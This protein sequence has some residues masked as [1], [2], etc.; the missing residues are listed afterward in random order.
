MASS[1][2]RLAW[3]DLRASGL[4]VMERLL[5]E[6]ALLRHDPLQ[7]SWAILGTHDPLRHRFIKPQLPRYVT[8]SKDPNPGCIIVMGIGGKPELLLN[9][10][11]V[12][13][14]GVVV[15]KRFSGGGTVVLDNHSIWTTFIGRTKD[16]PSIEPY[17]RSIMQWSADEVFTPAFDKM[18]LVDTSDERRGQKT[19]VMDNKSCSATENI[20]TV[21]SLP[22]SKLKNAPSL[23][24]SPVFELKEN[25]YVLGE[26]KIGGN[27]QSII[28][29]GWL[30]HTSF[31]W[32]FDAEHMEYLTLP[33]KR[34]DY[35][36]DR[37]HEEFLV[38]LKDYYGRSS[39]V[40]YQ[41]VKEACQDRFEVEPVSL[42]EAMRIVEDKGGMERWFEE[43]RTRIVSQF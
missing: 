3:L 1:A 15:I 11:L 41:S 26:R 12:K 39:R 6:E 17:P 42:K 32:D 31:L 10:E 22:K 25:D 37:Q 30:H 40:F 24:E 4:S 34:P 27:A 36:G 5:L 14:D 21:I 38:R 43:S 7:R 2:V 9:R 28:K 35:R 20:G 18:P 33:D 16:F 8:R 13:K 23:E 29:G 19:L